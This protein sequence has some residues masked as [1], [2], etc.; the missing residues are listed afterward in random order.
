MAVSVI[1][2]P[3]DGARASATFQGW[4][5]E[6]KALVTGLTP[7]YDMLVTATNAALADGGY[8]GL[9]ASYGSALLPNTFL[10]EY[11]PELVSN[12]NDTVKV[13]FVFRQLVPQMTTDIG[14]SL[15]EETSCFDKDGKLVK[16]S[17]TPAGGTTKEQKCTFS[18]LMPE[19]VITITRLE[20]V[21]P[22]ATS[23]AYAGK[24]NSGG[25][26]RDPGAAPRTWLCVSINGQ[27]R[28]TGI[29]L[30]TYQFAFRE[31]GWDEKVFYLDPQTGRIPPD[32]LDNDTNAIKT[33]KKY[34][35]A[36]FN[37]L[38]LGA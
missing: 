1:W 36:N 13:T 27:N 3:V 32:V 30:T 35:E 25:W 19:S 20:T 21:S 7:A 33:V 6:R 24:V 14:T 15:S 18:K 29:F 4:E 11:Q 28:G 23:R 16:V 31:E 5:I 38:G 26:S 34:K 8:S 22:G 17:Y 10:E 37:N 12:S 9:G 2:D